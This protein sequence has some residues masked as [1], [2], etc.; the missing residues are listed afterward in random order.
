MTGRGIDQ[1]LPHPSDPQLFESYVTSALV[2]V[3]LA[4]KVSGPVKRPVPFDYIWGDALRHLRERKPDAR[5]VNLET[6]VT[7]QDDPWPYKGIHYRMHPANVPCLTAAAIDCCVLANNHVLDWGREGLV[8]TLE[9]LGSVGI[10]TAG[11][12]RNAEQ[13]FTPAI[14]PTSAGGRVAVHAFALVSSGVPPEWRAAVDRPGINVLRDLSG[15]S[16]DVVK[17]QVEKHRRAGDIV[18]VSLH[19]GPNWGFDVD[20]AEQE[21][22]RGLVAEAG[23][24]IVHGHSSHHVKGIEV[25]RERLILYGCGDLLNDYEGIGGHATYRGDLALLYFPTLEA[26]SGRLLE[27]SMVPTRTRKMRIN[28]ASAEEAQWLEATLSRTGANLGTSADRA[29]DGTLRL[30][31]Q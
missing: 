4:E 12:G 14:L 17:R 20:P 16:L 19:W 31:W 24:D 30:R 9:T 29:P 27:L 6:A 5:I 15:H 25:Y 10:R 28:D 26:S 13:A 1:I 8:E 11:A 22:A 18:I 23:A 3:E 2:Y 21:F 7:T